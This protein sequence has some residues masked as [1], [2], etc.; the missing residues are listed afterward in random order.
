MSIDIA[1]IR[2]RLAHTAHFGTDWA[3][4]EHPD[5]WAVSYDTT[6]PQAGHL[7]TVADYAEPVADLLA[8]APRDL[9]S[10]LA[11]I[12]RLRAELLRVRGDAEEHGARS[13][14]EQATLAADHADTAA[15]AAAA[16]RGLSLSMDN[17]ARL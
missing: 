8:H 7:A 16:I 11:E 2:A 3:H 9:E 1:A 4:D 13:M 6:T 10:L 14:R 15:E 5:G 12:D 17:G